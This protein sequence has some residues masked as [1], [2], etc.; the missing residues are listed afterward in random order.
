MG[1][2]QSYEYITRYNNEPYSSV[3]YLEQCL[4][5]HGISDPRLQD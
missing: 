1:E 4:M 2:L 3:A 5:P